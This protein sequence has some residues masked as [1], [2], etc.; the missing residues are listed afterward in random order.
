MAASKELSDSGYCPEEKLVKPL[1]PST[2]TIELTVEGVRLDVPGA[3]LK[4]SS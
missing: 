2:V 3:F 1:T 4:A